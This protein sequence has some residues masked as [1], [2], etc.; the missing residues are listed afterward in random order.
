M[1]YKELIDAQI[2]HKLEDS[3]GKALATLIMMAASNAARV[4]IIEPTR[5]DYLRLVDAVCRDQRVLDM[6]GHSGASAAA[7]QWRRLNP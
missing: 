7:D 4:P 5:E 6:W 3:F 2:R 1:G